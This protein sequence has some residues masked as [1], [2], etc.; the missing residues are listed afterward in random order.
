MYKIN[1]YVV[2]K[3][4]VC[5]VSDIKTLRGNLYYMISP[6]DDSS[7]KISLPVDSDMI[8]P[9]I[10]PEDAVKMIENVSDI[11]VISTTND[12]ALEQAYKKYIISDSCIDLIRIIKT[13]YLRNKKRSDTGKK[14][15]SVDSYYY[16]EAEKK[17]YNELSLSLRLTKEQVKE[18]LISS[19]NK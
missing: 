18:Y 11:P 1:D 8:R 15:G 7:L 4:D 19:I 13:T 6:I 10:S 3:R 2:Y 16:E 17:L 5:I 9:I 14:L 12:K